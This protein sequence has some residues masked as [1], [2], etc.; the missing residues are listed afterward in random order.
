MKT[1]LMSLSLATLMLIV[2]FAHGDG[3]D[4]PGAKAGKEPVV[5]ESAKP[6]GK[7]TEKP[8][9]SSDAPKKVVV[10][11]AASLTASERPDDE[12]AIRKTG[13][14]FVEA[15]DRGDASAIAALFTADAEYIDATG[16]VSQGREAIADVFKECFASKAGGQMEIHI[17]SIRFL[18]PTVAI[19]DGMTAVTFDEDDEPSD[20]SYSAIH[21]KADGAWL[22]ASVRERA[23][24]DRRQHRAMLRQL[25]WLQGEWVDESPDTVVVF[26][27]EPA[28]GGNFLD[29]TFVIDASDQAPM[30]GTQ[31][32]GWDPVAGKLKAW[33]FDS[34]GGF[35]EGFWHRDEDRWILKATGVTSDGQT[36]SSTSIYTLVNEN[37]MTWQSVDHEVGGVE[38]PDSEV[39]TI[40]RRSVR[41]ETADQNV[42]SSK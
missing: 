21:V 10:D 32:I 5:N 42:P 29:R 24:K 16:N 28:P 20:I 22:T 3:K 18:S 38:L 40:I 1:A 9:D 26:S 17:H 25:A 2:G 37:T 23:P 19:E 11:G 36:A 6:P 8:K 7:V 34:E 27:C 30:M 41:P 39:V 31:R 13:Q 15:Y 35:A 14:S 12:S 33:I 4:P